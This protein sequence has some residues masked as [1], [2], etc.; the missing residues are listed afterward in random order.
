MSCRALATNTHALNLQERQQP[1]LYQVKAVQLLLILRLAVFQIVQ[2]GKVVC[3]QANP[4]CST[5]LV[6]AS[7]VSQL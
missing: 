5:G 7:A 2:P 3:A 6:V 4:I 1:K